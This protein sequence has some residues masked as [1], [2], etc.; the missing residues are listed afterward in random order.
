[1]SLEMT[2]RVIATMDFWALVA[3]IQTT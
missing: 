3:N 2:G 1:M